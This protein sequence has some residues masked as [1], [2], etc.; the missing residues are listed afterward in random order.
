MKR[1][2]NRF[3]HKKKDIARDS[4]CAMRLEEKF[5]EILTS[6]QE[7]GGEII[8]TKY[9]LIYMTTCQFFIM[10]DDNGNE[11]IKDMLSEYDYYLKV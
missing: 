8:Y 7:M 11:K 1:I 3:V 2:F 6:I 4:E 5:N 10:C 9:R